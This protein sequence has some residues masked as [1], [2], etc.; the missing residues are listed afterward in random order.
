MRLPRFR[1][2]GF[3]GQHLLVLPEPLRAEARAHPLLQG[4]HVTDAGYFPAAAYHQVKRP[5]GV[6]T[7]LVILC[8]KGKGWVRVDNETRPV[9]PGDLVWL[10]R[11]EPH[12]YGAGAENPW[13]IVWAHF[14]GR[15]VDAWGELLVGSGSTHPLVCPLPDDRLDEVAFEQVHAALERGFA[16]R[17]QVAAAAALRHSLSVVVQLA[18][19]PRGLRSAPE[20]VLASVEALRRD[21]QR[22]HRLE[23]LA[24]AAH[25]SVAHYSTLF[26]RQ[27][28]FAPID[29]LIRQRVQHACRLLDTTLLPVREIAERV[30]YADPYYFTR[31][32][33]RVMGQSPRTYR[34]VPKG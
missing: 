29:F 3:E 28:G 16:V 6:P 4:L 2:E 20:R 34:R 14:A 15:E 32:F 27:T 19:S 22:S 12:A 11:G 7:T 25:M 18:Y 21:W 17:H 13:T 9:S 1:R 10:P 5:G 30:G 23:E 33:R 26:R 24:A 31:C 8:L